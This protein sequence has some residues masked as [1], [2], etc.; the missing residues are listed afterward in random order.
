MPKNLVTALRVG[1]SSVLQTD[2]FPVQHN[3]T[4]SVFRYLLHNARKFFFML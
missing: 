4:Y 2:L 3:H 1:V